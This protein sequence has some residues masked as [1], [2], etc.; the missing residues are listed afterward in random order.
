M[1]DLKMGS[2]F[3][4]CLNHE[5]EGKARHTRKVSFILCIKI[6]TL[7]LITDLCSGVKLWLLQIRYVSV[8]FTRSLCINV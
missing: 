1:P 5:K 7:E 4:S 3:S 8:N 2:V 6:R